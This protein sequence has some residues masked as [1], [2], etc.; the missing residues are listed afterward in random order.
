MRPITLI[1]LPG[2]DGTGSLFRPFIDA[3]GPTFK[4]KVIQYPTDQA[5][6]YR[7]LLA[8]VRRELPVNEPYVVLGE[9]FSGPIAV[10]LAAEADPLL[11]GLILCCTFVRNP[12][13]LLS[14]LRFV[15]QSVPMWMP[16]M[17]VFGNLLLGKFSTPA[18]RLALAQAIAQVTPAVMRAR[19]HAVLC[20]DVTAQMT[21]VKIPILYLRATQDK[22]VPRSTS[23][24][25]CHLNP[26]TQVVNV[27]APHCPLQTTPLEA[28][29]V[30]QKFLINCQSTTP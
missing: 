29:Q 27:D 7:A 30:V 11:R 5:M 2:M 21:A 20:V 23:E 22:L 25:I 17:S 28:V 24:W 6:D 12:R 9:S 4:I 3:V 8:H 1:L 16:P 18:L 15:I 13:P 26:R 14:G 10:E 19:V